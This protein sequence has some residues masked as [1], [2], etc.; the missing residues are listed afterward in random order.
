MSDAIALAVNGNPVTRFE[1]ENS[2]SE[3]SQ[4]LFGKAPRDLADAEQKKAR[5]FALERLIAKE[6][7]FQAALARG[8]VASEARI[9]EESE[10]L[11]AQFPSEE[12]F[13]AK[14]AKLD[15]DRAMFR[16]IMR[17]DLGVNLLSSATLSQLP[18]ADKEQVEEIYRRY[19]QFMKVS[20]QLS[21]RH[22]LLRFE[23]DADDA[24]REALRRR[25]E[26]LSC[27]PEDF[28]RLA[29]EHS[30]CPSAAKGGDLGYFKRG[31][32][33]PAF[34]EA[35]FSQPP[36]LVGE[37]VETAYGLHRI[38]VTDRVP[39]TNLSL[40]EA[41]PKIVAYLKEDAGA[42]ALKDLTEGLRKDA[43]IELFI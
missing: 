6:L 18:E 34:E 17:K 36:G 24:A 39:E 8:L 32:M 9:T 21:A 2:L 26:G 42:Q 31:D 28:A 14:L 12:D 30:D 16:R 7:L 25:M 4:Q 5:E 33:V 10:K 15:I 20:E 41:A 37:V 27:S 3:F 22:I 38:L 29:H 43:R 40:E 19:P 13:F 35:A 1:Y 11:V 23:P